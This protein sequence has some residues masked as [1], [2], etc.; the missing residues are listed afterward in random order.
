MG[1]DAPGS[2][3]PLA[4]FC[5][6][7][8][9]R[10]GEAI[11]AAAHGLYV[12]LILGAWAKAG[13]RQAPAFLALNAAT[14]FAVLALRPRML[15]A[16]SG[17][18]WVLRHWYPVLF[19][20]M[21]FFESG[22]LVPALNGSSFDDLLV[23][24]DRAICGTDPTVW[25]QKIHHPA[26]SELLML[27]YVSYYFIPLVVGAALMVRHGV[28]AYHL[29][30][31]A[32]S[33]SFYASYIGYLLVPAIGPRFTLPHDLDLHGVFAF[34][35]IRSF[36]HAAE[37]RMPDCF[38]SGHTAVTLISLWFAWKWHRRV[39]WVLLPIGVGLIFSTVYLRYHYVV[40]LVAAVPFTVVPILITAPL[41]RAWDRL[42]GEP[43][44]EAASMKAEPAPACRS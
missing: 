30:L 22:V 13:I 41:A 39:F 43:A 34:E 11:W 19:F 7:H 25:M 12:L 37:G 44:A 6:R 20:G 2:P 32:I 1:T 31:T 17:V 14:F 29:A 38:P 21:F 3:S 27:C 40:D 10:L 18:L 33:L 35:A 9:V 36:L 28:R 42:R 4:A 8:D 24:I 23:R 26:L 5:R 16:R 15:A